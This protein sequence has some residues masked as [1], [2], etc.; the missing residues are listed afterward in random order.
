MGYEDIISTLAALYLLSVLLM[1][2]VPQLFTGQV[3]DSGI[4][5]LVRYVLPLVPLA[6]LV[7]R[8]PPRV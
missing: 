8:A 6:I 1:W 2:V 3:M 4:E 5:A 7:V